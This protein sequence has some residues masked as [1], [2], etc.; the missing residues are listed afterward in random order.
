MSDTVSIQPFEFQSD[1]SPPK[2]AEPGRVDMPAAEFALF[3]AQAR[4]DGFAEG[5]AASASEDADRMDAAADKFTSA[6]KDLLEL[7]EY[8]EA[9]SGKD[10]TPA[11]IRAIIQSAAQRLI[12]GQGD[13]FSTRSE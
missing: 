6:L 12:D 7:A 13:L 2:Q 1:F 3:L 11:P 10:E 8:L 9:I 4:A 5:R